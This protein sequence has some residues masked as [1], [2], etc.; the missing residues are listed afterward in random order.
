MIFSIYY[1]LYKICLGIWADLL[2][3]VH[4]GVQAAAAAE[5]AA[6]AKLDRIRHD[7]EHRR[8]VGRWE[9]GSMASRLVVVV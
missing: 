6:M 2:V 5:G 3:L 9:R 1:Y 4:G 7:N 8:E